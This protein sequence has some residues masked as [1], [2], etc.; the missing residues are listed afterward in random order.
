MQTVMTANIRR[1]SK[2]DISAIVGLL[3]DD[4]LGATR[5][6]YESPPDESY[7]QAFDAIDSDPNNEL[8]VATI[9]NEIV[10][11]LQLTF[12][13][14][15]TYQGG[16]RALIEGVRVA[17]KHRSQ[18]IGRQIVKRAIARAKERNC[19]MVQLTTDKTRPEALTFYEQLG[20]VSSHNGLKL[21][22][23]ASKES[24]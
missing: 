14:S 2:T 9:E 15:M 7:L 24:C 13:P 20:F 22:F 10:G 4:P 5:E 1:A 8:L 23:H 16:W 17:A 11:V 18:G 6:K 3:A 19:H 12:I 21:K